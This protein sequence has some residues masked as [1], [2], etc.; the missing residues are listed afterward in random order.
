MDCVIQRLELDQEELGFKSS[1]TKNT[2]SPILPFYPHLVDATLPK[3][4]TLYL[5]EGRSGSPSDKRGFKSPYT[6]VRDVVALRVKRCCLA[7]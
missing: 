1:F 5:A 3:M 2:M 6:F 7:F 4:G